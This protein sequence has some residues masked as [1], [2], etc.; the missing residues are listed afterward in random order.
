MHARNAERSRDAFMRELGRQVR[1]RRCALG[2]T[3]V[4]LADASGT[5]QA[6]ISR[7]EHGAAVHMPTLQIVNVLRALGMHHYEPRLPTDMEPDEHF[8]R[9]AQAFD[10][11]EPGRRRLLVELAQTFASGLTEASQSM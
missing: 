5:S 4:D 8:A 2:I 6:A 10:L 1:E 9:Y 11:I 3:Q 7:L